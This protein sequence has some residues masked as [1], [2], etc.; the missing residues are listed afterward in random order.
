VHSLSVHVPRVG[1][2]KRFT[3]ACDTFSA[4]QPRGIDPNVRKTAENSAIGCLVICLTSS[5]VLSKGSLDL[6]PLSSFSTTW[7]IC[8][9]LNSNPRQVN[10]KSFVTVLPRS[11]CRPNVHLVREPATS[12]EYFYFTRTRSSPLHWSPRATA[13]K[14]LVLAL[15]RTPAKVTRRGRRLEG[16]IVSNRT[17]PALGRRSS[18]GDVEQRSRLNIRAR[19]ADESE[20][21][22]CFLS[23]YRP[24]SCARA[25]DSIPC[26]P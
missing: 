20:L 12:H 19:P 14:S 6:Q 24:C 1:S 9:S 5:T 13:I 10:A 25:P 17:S 18:H 21:G 8:F 2:A 4:K 3:P 7:G 26:M 16:V 22:C 23:L 11:A 15:I